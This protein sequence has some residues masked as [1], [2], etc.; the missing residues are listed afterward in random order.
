MLVFNTLRQ[1]I[2]VVFVVIATGFAFWRGGRPE[3][4]CAAALLA[5]WLISPF[6]VDTRDW[7]DPQWAELAI[8]LSLFGLLLWFALR[9]DRYWPIWAAALTGLGVIVRISALVDPR[10]IPK[11]YMTA[12]GMWAYLVVIA[13]VVGT[14]L[15]ARR[16]RP[17]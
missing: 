15:E 8:D 9:A 11:A 13:L 16:I 7:V 1:Q 4:V 10:I 2:G 14:W 6:V 17:A 12:A 3:R 5:A